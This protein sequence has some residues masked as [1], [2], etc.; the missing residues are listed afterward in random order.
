MS[1]LTPAN[2]ASTPANCAFHA[3]EL[4]DDQPFHILKIRPEFLIHL[5]LV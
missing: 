1:P 2:F 3:I 5:N 4:R